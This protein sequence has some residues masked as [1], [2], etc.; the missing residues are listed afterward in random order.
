MKKAFGRIT[1]EY[2]LQ[3]LMIATM[4]FATLTAQVHRCIAD[5]LRNP[6]RLSIEKTA[7][8]LSQSITF[9]RSP[10]EPLSYD[11]RHLLHD[12]RRRRTLKEL[13]VSLLQLN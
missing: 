1:N 3:A 5:T 11:L 7:K 4:I 10:N 6:L 12:R 9:M 13:H 2:H 8:W